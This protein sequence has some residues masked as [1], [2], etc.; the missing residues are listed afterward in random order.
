[1]VSSVGIVPV[2]L[3]LLVWNWNVPSVCPALRENV[4]ID[5]LD[6]GRIAVRVIAT[7]HRRVI[8]HVPGRIEFLVQRLIPAADDGVPRGLARPAPGLPPQAGRRDRSIAGV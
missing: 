2:A 4:A 3:H 7:T 1:V 8:G 6:F 5:V